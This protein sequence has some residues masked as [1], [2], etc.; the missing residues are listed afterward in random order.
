MNG[1]A[2]MLRLRKKSTL[3]VIILISLCVIVVY[4]HYIAFG[5]AWGDDELTAPVGRIPII[6]GNKD[7]AWNSAN[8]TENSSPALQLKVLINSS[9]LFVLI[10]VQTVNH[11]PDEYVK[12]LLSNDTDTAVSDFIDA[13]LIQTRNFSSAENRSYFIEDQHYSGGVYINDTQTNFDGAA[14]VSSSGNTYS[15]YE[16]RIPFASKNNDII[17]DTSILTENSYAIKILFGTHAEG[18]SPTVQ[19]TNSIVIKFEI[20]EDGGN[21]DIDEFPLNLQIIS[22]VVF[23]IA[24]ISFIIIFVI[25]FQSRLKI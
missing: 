16:F 25:S 2:L 3:A 9:Y 14:N 21:G 19:P 7:S 11:N 5:F 6:D 24:G 15:Y 20:K 1:L 17:N 4:N 22:Y 13:K 8:T 10:E 23:F 18:E 12:I